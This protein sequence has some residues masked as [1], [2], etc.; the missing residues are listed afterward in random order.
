MSDLIFNSHKRALLFEH[1]A[2][3]SGSNHIADPFT[4]YSSEV[5]E[6]VPPRFNKLLIAIIAVASA[7]LGIWY[8]AKHLPTPTL[9]IHKPEP[10]VIEIVKPEEPPKVIE[11]KIPPITEKPKIPPVVEKPKQIEQPK[12]LPKTVEQP[13]P[14]AKAVAQPTPQKVEEAVVT[15]EAISEPVHKAVE[16]VKPVDDNLPVTEAKGYAGYLSNPAPEY[17]EQALERGWE[18]SVI[19]RVKV[20]ADGRPDTISVKQSSGKKLLDNAAIRTVKQWKFSPAL[21][22]KTP[23]E[24]WVDVPIHYQ[25][26]K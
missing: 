2:P 16:P 22:G 25:L 5:S 7:H 6:V 20:L 15:K 19:L 10:V 1:Y 24:G 18:G 11:P 23:V 17:P 9:E 21:K 13:K 8:I 26:P 4:Q 3:A 12:P 14:V